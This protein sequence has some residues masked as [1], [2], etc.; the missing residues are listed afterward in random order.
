LT[1]SQKQLK[2]MEKI[3]EGAKI[4]NETQTEEAEVQI[5]G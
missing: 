3:S 2:I 1:D 5:E 4:E